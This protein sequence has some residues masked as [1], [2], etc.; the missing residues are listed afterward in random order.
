MYL[1]A[2]THPKF[3][4]HYGAIKAAERIAERIKLQSESTGQPLTPAT[5]TEF[6]AVV[7][8]DRGGKP[9]TPRELDQVIET[10]ATAGNLVDYPT[11]ER[12][13]PMG[14]LDELRK[15]GF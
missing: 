15:L 2:L 8:A 11:E 5:V 13:V 4:V 10:L 3:G 6:A 9:L 14:D 7:Q 1:P 12:A